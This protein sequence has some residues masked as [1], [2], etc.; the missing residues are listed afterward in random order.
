MKPVALLLSCLVSWLVPHTAA[1]EQPRGTVLELHSCE[2]YAGGCIVSSEAPQGGRYMLRAW[3]FTGGTFA[4]ADFSGL[5]LALLQTSSGNLAADTSAADQSVV[6]LPKSASEGQR[7]ALFAWLK[8]AHREQ[9]GKTEVR[10]VPI[11]MAT[12][13]GRF[14]VSAGG[15]LSVKAASLETCPTGSC[16]EALWYSPRTA[17]TLF[18]VGVNQGSKVAEPFLKLKWDDAGKKSIFL[19]RF[20]ERTAANNLY[21]SLADL[22]GPAGKLF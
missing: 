17:N 2:L 18:T 3:K 11:E 13:N 1:A 16:G 20:G 4:G 7:D 21:V 9:L 19:A 22:C 15:F 8:S 5:E 6:Y 10:V 12:D 14:L